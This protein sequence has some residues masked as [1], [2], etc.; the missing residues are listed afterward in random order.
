MVTGLYAG[1]VRLGF[2]LPSG[3]DLASIHGPLMIC[4][5]FGTLVSLERAVALGLGWS[6][7]AP[8]GFALSAVLMLAGFPA[9]AS[10]TALGAAI[11]FL[12]AT[13]WIARLQFALF[14]FVLVA[15]TAMLTAG[16]ALWWAGVP[17]PD[18]VAWWLG[19]LVLTIAAERL[20]LSRVIRHGRV[21]RWLF[22]FSVA[23][24]A[25]GA[26]LGLQSQTGTRL[27]GVGLISTAAWLVRHDVAMRTVRM[28]GQPRF[29][30]TAMLAGYAWLA[31]TGGIMATDLAGE[32][33]YDL[34]LHGVLIGFVLSMVFGHALIIFPAIGGLLLTYRPTLYLPLALLH[35]SVLLR[36]GGSL[37]DAGPVRL[38]S[39]P[40]TVAAL[41]IFAVLLVL[42]RR[43]RPN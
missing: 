23:G 42:G 14:T 26:A 39:G 12:G 40:S 7:V 28:P 17:V 1:L 21:A 13:L 41:A 34:A 19:F 8:A 9:L 38:A 6:Y 2:D 11:V 29:M 16:C 20:E 3:P 27:I 32:F 18:L 36:V 25:A 43:V 33:G 30:A 15:G 35:L 24:V 31:V 10:F 5:L 4:G 22:L 37:L